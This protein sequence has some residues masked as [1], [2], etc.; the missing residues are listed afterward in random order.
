MIIGVPKEIKNNENRVAITPPGVQAF[1]AAGHTVLVEAGAGVGSGIS[2]GEYLAAGAELRQ[3]PDEV[4]G[5][6]E[7]IIKVKEPVEAEYKRV[8][9]GQIVFTYFHFA[10]SEALTK[11][12]LDAG[13]IGVAYETVE[14][15]D[16]SLP[17]L[18]PMS[19]VAGC[20]A[21]HIGAY[22]LARP[23]GGR[24]VLM[25]GVPGVE[26]AHVVVIGGGIVGSNAARMAA[27]L[28][29]QVTIFE[30]SAKRMRYLYDVMPKNIKILQSNQH[31]IEEAVVDADLVIGAVLIPGAKAP[32]LVTREMVKKMKPGAVI[33]DV[34]VDQGGCI[35]TTV[36]TTHEN[37]TYYVDGVLHYCVA[38][39]PG[40]FPRTSTY[41]LTNATLPYAL[42]IA[43]KGVSQ[44]LLDDPALLKG[45]NVYRGKVTYAAVGEA[46][47]LA[48]VDARE[49]LKELRAV[50]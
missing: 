16:G 21:A 33:V 17:L 19:E 41:A 26:P 39:M 1:K 49:V 38:N 2:D 27:G 4:F 42:A 44:A 47:G 20:M 5:E 7:M 31:N 34:A 9:P 46:F 29:A 23:R 40:A 36:P 15:S 35:E 3:T 45:L 14:L 18:S 10:S 8:K 32:R 24:G 6:A 50:S 37:P 22:Y 25:G 12:M 43:N 11:A 48:S 28:G 13:I 30:V